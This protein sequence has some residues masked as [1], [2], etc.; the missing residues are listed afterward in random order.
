MYT[1]NLFSK[2][3]AGDGKKLTHSSIYTPTVIIMIMFIAI[4]AIIII[5]TIIMIEP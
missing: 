2:V 5:V 3:G 1:W 4:I